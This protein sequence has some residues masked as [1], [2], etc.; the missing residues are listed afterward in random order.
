[1]SRQIALGYGT[2]SP[3]VLE[4]RI[5]ALESKV[6][7]LTEAVVRLAHALENGPLAVPADEPAD[8]AARPAH[9]LLFETRHHAESTA[10]VG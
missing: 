10:S 2:P 3:A 4:N 1:M 6:I 8:R 5:H 7:I 9:E